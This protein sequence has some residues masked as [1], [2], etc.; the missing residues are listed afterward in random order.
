MKIKIKYM[1]FIREEGEF[2]SESDWDEQSEMGG[3]GGG[4]M[5]T[6]LGGG[7][8]DTTLL[9]VDEY[10]DIAGISSAREAMKILPEAEKIKI[11]EQA[12]ELIV[13]VCVSVPT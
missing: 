3:V 9:V 6:T 2:D 8:G 1:V 10:P 7:G 5:S 11:A 13:C 4:G 12:R